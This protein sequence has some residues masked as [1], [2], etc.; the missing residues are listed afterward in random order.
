MRLFFK[1]LVDDLSLGANCLVAREDNQNKKDRT[2]QAATPETF[3]DRFTEAFNRLNKNRYNWVNLV[4]LRRELSEFAKDQFDA[5]L[6]RLRK[7]NKF[8]LNTIQSNRPP[9]DEERQAGIV[10]NGELHPIVSGRRSN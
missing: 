5:E 8:E 1:E 6:Y 3:E 10:V 9:T 7:E 2:M 4:D